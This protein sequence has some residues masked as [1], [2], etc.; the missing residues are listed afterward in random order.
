MATTRGSLA[1]G[2]PVEPATKREV[3]G[4]KHVLRA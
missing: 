1:K 2:H 4:A 3:G